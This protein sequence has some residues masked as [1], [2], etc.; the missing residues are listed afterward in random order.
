[1]NY[2]PKHS[3]SVQA[4][5]PDVHQDNIRLECQGFGDAITAIDGLATNLDILFLRQYRTNATPN[6]FLVINDQNSHK[7]ANSSTESGRN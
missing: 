7:P 3:V 6:E 1:V 5:H 4:R 2:P